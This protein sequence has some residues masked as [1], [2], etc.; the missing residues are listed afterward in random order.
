MSHHH[1]ELGHNVGV[2]ELEEAVVPDR[3]EGKRRIAQRW[4]EFRKNCIANA[5][6]STIGL[7]GILL[8]PIVALIADDEYI[9][10]KLQA[11]IE[12]ER[13]AKGKSTV[14]AVDT[15]G[16]N[17]R[18]KSASPLTKE[19]YEQAAMEHLARLHFTYSSWS[20][21]NQEL[22]GSVLLKLMVDSTGTVVRVDPVDSHVTNS[23]FIKTVIDDVREWKFPK[24]SAEAAEITVPLLFIPKSMDAGMIVQWER[25]I[26][27]M[28]HDET[29]AAPLHVAAKASIAGASEKIP[30][31]PPALP[32]TPHGDHT[33]IAKAAVIAAPK[34]KTEQKPLIVV[35]ANRPLSIRN[36]PRFAS[37]SIREV[38]EGARL[39]ILESRGD[40]L[41]V[42]LAEGGL[43]GFVRKEYVSPINGE[44]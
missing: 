14:L 11:N 30:S 43:I 20:E 15:S 17:V 32:P 19:L 34:L 9:L 4:Y 12:T 10:E 6:A 44:P 24:G 1:G 35:K 26:R 31:P 13:A 16:L 33:T 36:N 38:G 27:G 21:R 25:N 3:N 42:R 22:M 37:N 29:P 18:S 40:W 5:T 41:K 7:G 39:S 8:I 23:S 2:I 28:Q